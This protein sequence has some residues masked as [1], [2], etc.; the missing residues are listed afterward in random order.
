MEMISFGTVF[1]ELVFGQLHRLPAPGEEVF[2]DEFAISCGGAVTSATAAAA[3]GVR[4]GL[5]TRLGDDLGSQVVTEHCAAA[6]VDLS[7]SSQV[8]GATAGITVVLNF[9]D[10]RGFVTHLPPSAAAGEQAE[11]QRWHSVVRAERPAWCYLHPGRW[12]P[13]FLGVARSLGCKIM[14]DMSLGDESERDIVIECVRLADIFVPNA[15]ELLALTGAADLAAALCSAAGWGAQ[16]VVTRGAQGALVTSQDGSVIEVADGV[17]EV[18]V[19]DLTGAG[20]NFAGALIAALIGGASLTQAVVAA[21]AAGSQAVGRL[22]AVGELGTE[23]TGAG[24]PLRPMVLKDVAD[25]L[26]AVSRPGTLGRGQRGA[27]R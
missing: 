10:D 13:P 16:L 19:R 21:N 14:L 12:V 3:A 22:G 5:A 7:P 20:D 27:V 25:A 1:L 26:A 15:A 8:A 11:I 18:P 23:S 4:A 2:T 6:G 24:W 17:K 9:D